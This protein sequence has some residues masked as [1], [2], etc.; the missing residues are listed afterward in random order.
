M[1]ISSDR[2]CAFDNRHVGLFELFRIF[3]GIA[4]TSFGGYMAMISVVQ[5]VVVE[6][7]RLLRDDAV[8]DGLS[9]ASILPGPTAVNMVAYVGYRLRGVAGAVVCVSAA[10][11]P[12][13][14]LMVVFSEAYLR[15]GAI[16]AAGKAFLGLVPAVVA[17][18]VAAAWRLCRTTLVTVHEGALAM[19]S[20]AVLLAFPGIGIT[21]AIIATAALAGR[22]W[23]GERSSKGGGALPACTPPVSRNV[24]KV[25]VRLLALAVF[26]V[27]VS[28]LPTIEA[29]VLV[30]LATAFAGM[31]VLMFGGGYAFV[32]MFQQAV[33]DGY[34][35]VTRQEF[36]DALALGQVT[37][38]PIMVS[39]T[40]I[41]YKVAGLGGAIAATAGM[42]TP[43][44]VLTV[45]CARSLDGAVTSDNVKASIRGVRA[46][47]TGM[48]I[49]AAIVVG[50][51]A[52]PHWMSVVLFGISLVALMRFRV[53]AAWVVFAAAAAGFFFL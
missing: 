17:I 44:A 32:P 42:F 52:A 6:R 19:V 7:R 49:T 31:S 12:A 40:F 26:P 30:K 20:A 37:P 10:L 11:L 38:G 33:V 46:A 3:L 51:T 29:G 35:W 47:A 39:A 5:Q 41:G 50:K 18:I 14:L 48:V 34:G 9:L 27:L 43:T 8:L 25:N 21:L 28:P 53:S 22:F 15:W 24:L 2:T 1:Q 4:S 45:L 16:P 36:V 23:F 13:F